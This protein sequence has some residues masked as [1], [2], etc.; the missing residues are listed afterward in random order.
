LWTGARRGN[1]QRMRWQQLDLDRAVWKIPGEQFKTRK[2][3][4]VA[5]C[6]EAL[7]ILK[8]RRREVAGEWVFPSHGASG[9]L[10]EPKGGWDRLRERSG[11]ADL[12]IHDLRHTLASWQ[13]ANG[14]SLHIIGK[15]LGHARAETTRRYS[16]LDLDPIRASVEAAARAI[17]DAGKAK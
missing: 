10:I 8:R 11:L 1:V 6:P 14:A 9:H 17:A 2:P 5:L 13:A 3:L 7:E 4:D 15:S 12:R 16:H